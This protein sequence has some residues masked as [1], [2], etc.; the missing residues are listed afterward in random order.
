M[1]ALLAVPSVATFG[2]FSRRGIAVIAAIAATVGFVALVS[3]SRSGWFAIGTTMLLVVVASLVWPTSRQVL[4]RVATSTLRGTRGRIAV[5]V[6]VVA[7]V[8][9]VA[10]LA[11]IIIR[12]AGEGGEDLR[13]QFAIVALRLFASS[14]LVGTGPGT[15]VIQRVAET[16]SPETDYYVPYAHDLEVQTLAELGIVGVIAGTVLMFSLG[17]L[18]WRAASGADQSRQRWAIV[19]AIGLVYLLL[20]QVFDFYANLPAVLA[21]AVIPIAYLDA[22]ASPIPAPSPPTRASR[23]FWGAGLALAGISVVGLIVQ[24]IPAVLASEAVSAANRGDWAGADA[25]ARLAAALD[26]AIQS[27]NMTAGLTAS[28]RGDHEAAAAYFEAVLRQTDFPE[29]WL[30]LAAEQGALGRRDEAVASLNHAIRVGW[31]R[32][33]VSM[34]AGD[35]ALRLGQEDIAIQALSGALIERASLAGDP[36]WRAD[37]DRRAIFPGVVDVAISHTGPQTAWEIRLLAGQEQQARDIAAGFSDPFIDD[38]IS[39]W[40]GDRSA[41]NRLFDRCRA[42]PLDLGPL[43]WCARVA[44]HSGDAA[45]TDRFRS[46][47]DAVVNG[48]SS[49]GGELRVTSAVSAGAIEGDAASIWGTFT[50]RRE[51]PADLLVPILVHLK[52][53]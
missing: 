52:L 10:V 30:D 31:E 1:V 16:R 49:L 15:W 46:M 51:I 25:P 26:P 33:A 48:S 20:H 43:L 37:P 36:W 38:V 53:E 34:A 7:I 11:P 6:A 44:E 28:H 27:Y 24:E 22:T 3:G 23:L 12:R 32:A 42:Q 39:A 21:A 2:S 14:P 9:A 17:S 35:L 4:R 19:G 45:T 8:L 40:G 29:A 5:T 47:A 41:A 13:L 50:Y 18:F